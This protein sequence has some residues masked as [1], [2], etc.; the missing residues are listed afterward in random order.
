MATGPAWL[1][2]FVRVNGRPITWL[3]ELLHG[4]N[5]ATTEGRW[6]ARR[7][8]SGIKDL[9]T[10]RALD[11][12]VFVTATDDTGTRAT[13]TI[14]C[15]QANAAGDTITFTYGGRA[16]VLTEGA[17]GTSGFARGASDAA[18]AT[19]LAACINAHPIL[20]GIFAATVATN[21]VT[22][23][24]K[25]PG[26]VMHSIVMTTSDATA[27]AIVALSGGAPGAAAMFFQHIQS[28]KPAP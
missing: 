25:V 21:V 13:G 15:T 8:F 12:N 6:E 2:I 4:K 14:T 18:C 7:I 16:I 20:S 19:N 11:L 10:G 27:F 1:H 28:G 23:A 17:A 5:L 22:V 24:G 26:R 9:F 3:T